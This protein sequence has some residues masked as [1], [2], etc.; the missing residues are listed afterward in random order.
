MPV[1]IGRGGI[2]LNNRRLIE[3]E[4]HLARGRRALPLFLQSLPGDEYLL[5]GY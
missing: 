3:G 1:M 5:E 2:F 4:Y